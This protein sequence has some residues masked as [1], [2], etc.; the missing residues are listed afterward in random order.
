MQIQ[1]LFRDLPALE[2]GEWCETLLTCR[3]VVIER[4]ASSER[5]APTLYD[6]VQ[7][8]WVCLLQGAADLW[9][10]G[11]SVTLVAGDSLFIP[12]HRPHRVLRTS[13]DPPC[14]WLAVHIHPSE[15]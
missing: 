6:Q 3:Q 1:N 7:D 4:I 15:V 2:E 12:A 14:L 10:D 11:E 13:G 5:V 8:E 9:I